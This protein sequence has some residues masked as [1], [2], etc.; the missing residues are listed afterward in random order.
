[1]NSTNL[2]NQITSQPCILS[3]CLSA[4][5]YLH[6][7]PFCGCLFWWRCV[8][9]LQPPRT[10]DE[11]KG[12]QNKRLNSALID[13]RDDDDDDC[14]RL[15]RAPAAMTTWSCSPPRRG[16]ERGWRWSRV[17]DFIVSLVITFFVKHHRFINPDKWL[18]LLCSCLRQI[19]HTSTWSSNVPSVGTPEMEVIRILFLGK[20]W[21][22]FLLHSSSFSAVQVLW[23]ISLACFR[24]NEKFLLWSWDGRSM[25]S[26]PPPPMH[27]SLG[28]PRFESHQWRC[29]LA[30][31]VAFAEI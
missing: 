14:A 10:T 9:I 17:S 29:R 23:I 4:G 12:G 8:Q 31:V 7:S 24:Q 15:A 20:Y 1:M 3:F 6:S 22:S 18:N 30:V 2:C 25:F 13:L 21:S 27:R 5:M 19:W 26:W 16:V 28:T 11:W